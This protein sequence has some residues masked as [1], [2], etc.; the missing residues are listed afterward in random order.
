[1]SGGKLPGGSFPEVPD[2][3]CRGRLSI[4]SGYLL[5]GGSRRGLGV[6]VTV[7]PQALVPWLKGFG[8]VE[9]F[10]NPVATLSIVA[11]VR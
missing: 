4:G 7:M 1:M 2:Q 6:K 5:A 11:P 8:N 9:D 3:L 10:V